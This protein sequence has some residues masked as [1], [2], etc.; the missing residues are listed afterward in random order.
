MRIKTKTSRVSGYRGFTLIELLIV[1]AII[2]ILAAIAI[3][4]FL[5]QREKAKNRALESSAKSSVA[6]IQAWMDAYMSNEPIVAF[7]SSGNEMC[8]ESVTPGNRTCQQIFGLAAS[9][10]YN[11]KDDD[12]SEIVD[13]VISH[14]H[15]REEKSPFSLQR[16]SIPQ[17]LLPV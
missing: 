3:P 4:S 9:L 15:G 13:L 10:T 7:S 14:H 17:P 2:G 16:T 6:E 12:I 11:N 8:L 5:G 1:I